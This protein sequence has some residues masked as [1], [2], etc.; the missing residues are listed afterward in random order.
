[1]I[2]MPTLPDVYDNSLVLISGT[3][4]IARESRIF[5]VA[6]QSVC[7]CPSR[8]SLPASYAVGRLCMTGI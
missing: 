3:F 4:S 7:S 6:D 2:W 1:M 5:A 8:R